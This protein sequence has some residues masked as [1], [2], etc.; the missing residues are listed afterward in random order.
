MTTTATPSGYIFD[1]ADPETRFEVEE[2]IECLSHMPLVA[3]DLGDGSVSDWT[4]TILLCILGEGDP[5]AAEWAVP[6][7]QAAA[8]EVLSR[9]GYPGPGFAGA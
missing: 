3:D 9:I 5:D 7:V 4:L 2:A 8:R 6:R 1:P